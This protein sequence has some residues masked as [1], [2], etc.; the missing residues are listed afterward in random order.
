MESLYQTSQELEIGSL[1][2]RAWQLEAVEER[3]RE[4]KYGC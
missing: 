3:K 1:P 2:K 4:E